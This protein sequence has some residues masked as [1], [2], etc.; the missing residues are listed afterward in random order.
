MATI[1]EIIVPG[2]I[3]P[4]E[5]RKW[6]IT[7]TN[8]TRSRTGWFLT[9]DCTEDVAEVLLDQYANV[10]ANASENAVPMSSRSPAVKNA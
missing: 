7:P 1:G 6:I 3:Q 9:S 2:N 8:D 4:P 5:A 10:P